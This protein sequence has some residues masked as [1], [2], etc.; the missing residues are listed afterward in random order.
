LRERHIGAFCE[1][2]E[3]MA[4]H[5]RKSICSRTVRRR[6]ELSNQNELRKEPKNCSTGKDEEEEEVS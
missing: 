5:K 3:T 1:Q 6:K 4:E 2:G